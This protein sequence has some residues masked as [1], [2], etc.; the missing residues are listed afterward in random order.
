M[1]RYL[2]PVIASALFLTGCVMGPNYK[3]PKVETPPSF[4]GDDLQAGDVSIAD[5]RWSELFKDP[6]LTDLISTALSNNYDMRIAAER[7]L[8]ER[9]Q[10]GVADSDLFPTLD[11]NGTLSTNRNSQIGS[12]RFLP[13][14]VS[15]DVS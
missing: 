9:A 7:V 3:R 5:T 1:K 12:N 10:L 13:A 11:A 14:G 8:Q 4:R 2:I 15:N 6:V